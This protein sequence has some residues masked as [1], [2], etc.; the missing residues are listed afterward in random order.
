MFKK[1]EIWIVYLLFLIFITVLIFFGFLVK[2]ELVG[3]TK[4]GKISKIAL[5]IASIPN[6]AKKVFKNELEIKKTNSPSGFQIYS[7]NFKKKDLLLLSR[8][9][10]KKKRSIVEVVDLYTLEVLHTFK[11][12]IDELNRETNLNNLNFEKLLIDNS[13]KRS[14]IIHPLIQ[15]NGDLIF[16]MINSPLVKIDICGNTKWVQ[17]DFIF[18]HSLESDSNNNIYSPYTDITI[19]LKDQKIKSV[20]KNIINTNVKKNNLSAYPDSLTDGYL[21]ISNEGNIIENHTLL[22]IFSN[23]NLKSYLHGLVFEGTNLHLNDVQ[24][25]LFDTKF[26]KKDDVFLS[27]RRPSIIVLYRPSSGKILNI[28]KG[29]FSA[30]HDVDIISNKEI[31]IFNNNTYFNIENNSRPLRNS[32]IIIYDFEKKEYRKHSQNFFEKNSISSISQGLYDFLNDGSVIIEENNNGKLYL[33][34]ERNELL[35]MYTNSIDNG[36]IY[37]LNWSRVVANKHYH[38]IKKLLK[39]PKCS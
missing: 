4:F 17:D 15:S 33:L 38:K 32:E 23:N 7:K 34:N 20:Y 31:A 6:Y 21:K 30:Q 22:D 2:Q 25:A 13:S 3:K 11:P 1:I 28:I 8:Y 9:D 14:R 5:E 24:P 16:K 12:N 18:H 10:G 19:P 27:F 26:W 37:T 35:W 36:Y 29:D 39:N